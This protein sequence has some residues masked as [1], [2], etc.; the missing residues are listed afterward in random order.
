MKTE[1]KTETRFDEKVNL[2]NLMAFELYNWVYSDDIKSIKKLKNI[3]NQILKE[4][5]KNK[6]LNLFKKQ[7][8]L[9]KVYKKN[10]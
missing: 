8:G 4:D 1:M 10:L 3:A 5:K 7:E 2:T 6:N 9:N